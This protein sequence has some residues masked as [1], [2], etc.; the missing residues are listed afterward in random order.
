MALAAACL[1]VPLL[2]MLYQLALAGKHSR[3]TCFTAFASA[4]PAAPMLS[5]LYQLALAGKHLCSKLHD[6]A[7]LCLPCCSHAM[8]IV[9]AGFSWEAFALKTTSLRS[10][11]LNVPLCCAAGTS[12]PHMGCRPAAQPQGMYTHACLAAALQCSHTCLSLNHLR[13]KHHCVRP[14]LPCCAPAVHVVPAGFSWEAFALERSEERR[15]GKECR[16]RWS[17]YH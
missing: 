13:H 4:C 6:G 9:P 7:G 17:P 12:Q 14:R 2:R 15:V 10:H 11:L 1:A 3:W 5:M 16:S 8:H